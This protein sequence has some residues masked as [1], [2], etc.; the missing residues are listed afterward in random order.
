MI[1]TCATSKERKK[2]TGE[3]SLGDCTF[4]AYLSLAPK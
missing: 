1:A 2:N 3:D 4:S